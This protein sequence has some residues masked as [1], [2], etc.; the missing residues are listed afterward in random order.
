MKRGT[1]KYLTR[2]ER[3]ALAEYL[4]RLR[5]QF[6]DEVQRVILYGSKV[7]G[8]FDAESDIDVFVVFKELDQAREDALSWIVLDVDLKYAVLLSDFLVSEERFARMANLQEPL[9]QDLMEEGVD[10]WTKTPR[11]LFASVSKKRVTMSRG[12][13]NL[14]RAARIAKPSVV[15]TTRSLQSR[16]RRS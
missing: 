9:Y 11:S 6:G 1:L 16:A 2:R 4:T 7:R 15:R 5:E 13:V 12:R 8:D 10:V 3:A 14:S